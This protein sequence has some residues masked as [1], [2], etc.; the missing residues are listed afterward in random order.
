M[1]LE[2]F[3]IGLFYCLIGILAYKYPQL[4]AGYNTASAKEKEAF[5]MHSFKS[6]MRNGFIGIG[7]L[8]MLLGVLCLF[9]DNEAVIIPIMIALPLLL[10]IWLVIRSKQCWKNKSSAK[11]ERSFLL[12]FILFSII[13][14]GAVI[15][16]L[17]HSDTNSIRI[18]EKALTVDGAFGISIPFAEISGIQCCDTLPVIL[19]RT[20]GSAVNHDL[21]GKFK[22]KDAGDCRMYV[23]TTVP[24]FIQITCRDGKTI[25]L[26]RTDSGSTGTL[27]RLI[28]QHIK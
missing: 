17:C 26:N 19:L 23:R 18:D 24:P 9:Y 27:Y 12:C 21:R 20:G 3:I 6:S 2:N 10:C 4:I 7:V 15:V 28:Q 8:S 5:D 14:I 16:V 22:V 25:Y 11:G 1:M 13:L